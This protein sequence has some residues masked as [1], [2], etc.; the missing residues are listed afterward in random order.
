MKIENVFERLKGDGYLT[1]QQDK[2]LVEGISE[3]F[4]D[5]K[6]FFELP[7]EVKNK[8]YL[9]GERISGFKPQGVEFAASPER[10]DTNETFSY[11]LG[12]ADMFQHCESSIVQNFVENIRKLQMRLDRVAGDILSS[13]GNQYTKDYQPIK[14]ALS[15]WVQVNFYADACARSIMQDEHEDGHIIT[16]AMSDEP[17][18]EIK[19][20]NHTEYQQVEHRDMITVMPGEL[21][22]V[23]SGGD[24]KPLY[25]RVKSYQKKQR[26]SLTYFLN[27]NS[28]IDHLAPWKIN[29]S[30]SD[31]NIVEMSNANPE[32]FGLPNLSYMAA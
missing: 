16:L 26:I 15:S 1:F 13:I 19:G 28:N 22:T 30:N 10:P 23:L 9:Q 14:T 32:K 3:V 5:A 20:S 18:L 17:G 21:L 24:I 27:P 7:E 25:H 2:R 12:D 31:I 6:V 4:K 29:D 11:T 8:F